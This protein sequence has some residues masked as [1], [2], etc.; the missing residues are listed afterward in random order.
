MHM[1]GQSLKKSPN[2]LYTMLRFD[3][4][5]SSV[6]S[7]FFRMIILYA[8]ALLFMVMACAPWLQIDLRGSADAVD[9]SN[10]S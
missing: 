1:W 6:K 8:F 3:D 9:F 4:N 5:S 7:I 2:H 10:D